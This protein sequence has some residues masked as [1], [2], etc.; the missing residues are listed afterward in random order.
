MPDFLWSCIRGTLRIDAA[1]TGETIN[2]DKL[3]DQFIGWSKI[4]GK[5]WI[6][7]YWFE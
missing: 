1:V 4:L 6:M 3:L 5:L 2:F 7:N